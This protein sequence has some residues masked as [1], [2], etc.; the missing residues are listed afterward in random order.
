MRK[1]QKY[2]GRPLHQLHADHEVGGLYI[3]VAIGSLRALPIKV[4][5][6]VDLNVK[7]QKSSEHVILKYFVLILSRVNY[8]WLLVEFD[9]A[10]QLQVTCELPLLDKS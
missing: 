6:L 9:A 3:L 5:L 2:E 8:E 7:A 4:G 1:I 10:L